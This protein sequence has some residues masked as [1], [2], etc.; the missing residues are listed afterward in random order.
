MDRK[1]KFI[2]MGAVTILLM[3]A[4]QS[5]AGSSPTLQALATETLP[6]PTFTATPEGSTLTLPFDFWTDPNTACAIYEGQ[7]LS[8]LDKDGWHK[9][10]LKPLATI[11]QCPDGRI[12]LGVR[13]HR[14][15]PGPDYGSYVKFYALANNTLFKEV[16]HD[17]NPH[18][19]G[20]DA[21]AC[22]AGNEL[23]VSYGAGTDFTHFDGAAWTDYNKNTSGSYTNNKVEIAVAPNGNLWV[24]IDGSIMGRAGSVVTF[25]GTEW[26]TIRE[27]SCNSEPTP[28]TPFRFCPGFSGVTVDENGNVW[29]GG[30]DG[31]EKYDGVQWTTFP[32]P[33]QFSG[34]VLFYKEDKVWMLYKEAIWTFDSRIEMW[35]L[36]IKLG[37]LSDKFVRELQFDGQGRLWLVADDGLYVYDGLA[38]IYYDMEA[39][40]LFGNFIDQIIVFGDGPALPR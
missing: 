14:M 24:A 7:G 13:E 20:V 27:L 2:A 15:G 9:Y 21:I 32:D 39:A 18:T 1:P 29:V 11:A 3:L 33:E 28:G 22:G 10:E 5:I 37:A 35:D 12:Y 6:I 26:Q 8:C 4:C 23:W 36:Q 25:D 40:D 38:W 34:R 19:F 17:V 30:I 16:G 31:L